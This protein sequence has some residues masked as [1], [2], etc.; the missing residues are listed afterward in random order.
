MLNKSHL[1]EE[2]FVCGVGDMLKGYN[3]KKRE[4]LDKEVSSQG[5]EVLNHQCEQ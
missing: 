4:R 2:G 1:R 3:P 5:L